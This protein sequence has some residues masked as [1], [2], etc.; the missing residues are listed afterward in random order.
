MMNNSPEEQKHRITIEEAEE[1]N[2]ALR[3]AQALDP[4]GLASPAP[5]AHHARTGRGVAEG[6]GKR[7]FRG[8]QRP[9]QLLRRVAGQP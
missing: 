5:H 7:G 4:Q 3:A 8:H 1:I 2:E 9:E 6:H